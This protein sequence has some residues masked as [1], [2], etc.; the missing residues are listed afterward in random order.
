[1]VG[2]PNWIAYMVYHGDSDSGRFVTT[3]LLIKGIGTQGGFLDRKTAQTKEGLAPNFTVPD[4]SSRH[5][6]Y[7]FNV[8]GSGDP[9]CESLVSVF[10]KSL[11]ELEP[12]LIGGGRAV[13]TTLILVLIVYL[14]QRGFRAAVRRLGTL[15]ETAE[16][17]HIQKAV[18]LSPNRM[19]QMLV[20]SLRIIRFIILLV[21][22][23]Y[24]IPLM[25]SFFPGTAPFAHKVM[26]YVTG[27]TVKAA[28]AIVGY[29]PKL[30]TLIL[31]IVGI[32]YLLKFLFFF[33]SALK[34][35]EIKVGGFDPEWADQTYRLLRIA[36]ILVGVMISYPF[37]PGAGSEIFK[38]FSI[39][40]GAL[41]TLG[42]TSAVN[43]ITSGIVLTYTKA[44]RVGDRVRIGDTLGDI[45][46]KKL[47]VTRL[48]TLKNEEVTFPNG[49]V[50]G[51]SIVNLSAAATKDGLAVMASAGIGYDVDWRKIRELM[52]KAAQQT[53]G[54]L[55]EPEPFV[56]ESELGDFAV[57]YMVIG[58][59]KEPKRARFIEAELRRNILD[60]FNAEGVEIMTP[61]VTSVRDANQPAIPDEYSPKPFSSPGIKILSSPLSRLNRT[62]KT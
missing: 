7:R 29:L 45:V 40:V 22:F 46:E 8:E 15:T 44:F 31:I 9:A 58:K 13:I 47:F 62:V 52:K 60:V 38:G 55:S 30:A 32:K 56:L 51:D 59:T 2:N 54:I 16:G 53:P 19:R 39:F 4:D 12:Y 21:L 34:K 14:L 11:T 33:F 26:P 6:R 18:L 42:S 61:S 5:P 50:L 49:Q 48:R 1:M 37:L 23:Y 3:G 41:I 10:G 20:L 17:V 43:N 36:I 25:L 57:T 35:E 24:Y 27:P 28:N